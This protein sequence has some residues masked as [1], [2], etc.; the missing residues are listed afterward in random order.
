MWRRAVTK[1]PCIMQVL[2][3]QHLDTTKVNHMIVDSM[4]KVSST[5]FMDKGKEILRVTNFIHTSIIIQEEIPGQ[6]LQ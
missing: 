3:I 1:D 4:T 5:A 6:K 2:I